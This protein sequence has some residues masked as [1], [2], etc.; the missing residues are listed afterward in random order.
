MCAL[1]ETAAISIPVPHPQ[2]M[3]PM[4]KEDFSGRM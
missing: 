2:M 4:L 3:L 1:C